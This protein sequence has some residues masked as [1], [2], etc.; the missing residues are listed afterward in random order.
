MSC[1]MSDSEIVTLEH[2]ETDNILLIFYTPEGNNSVIE[3]L[4]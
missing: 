4:S 3:R 2:D 1:Q